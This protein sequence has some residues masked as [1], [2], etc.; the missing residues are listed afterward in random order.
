M[1]LLVSLLEGDLAVTDLVIMKFF[2]KWLNRDPIAE[3]GFE[4]LRGRRPLHKT[5]ADLYEF[6]RNDP[7]QFVDSYGLAIYVCVRPTLISGYILNHAYFWDSTT[8]TS[9]GRDHFSAGGSAGDTG[10][11]GPSTDSCQKVPGSDGMESAVMQCC[12]NNANNG[13]FVP[14][15]NDCHNSVKNCLSS[16]GLSDPGAPYLGGFPSPPPPLPPPGQG[17]SICPVN[18]PSSF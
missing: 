10:E 6:V 3:I 13:T 9:C 17:C 1:P 2:S 5:D 11:N 8:G 4:L 15:K 16:N 18:N 7:I 12:R 14:F